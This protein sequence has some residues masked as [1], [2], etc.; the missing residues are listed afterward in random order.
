[1]S[2]YPKD[3]ADPVT[4]ATILF[5]KWSADQ[6][7]ENRLRDFPHELRDVIADAIREERVE[8]ERWR[9][10]HHEASIRLQAHD[11]GEEAAKLYERAG[12]AEELVAKLGKELDEV[13]LQLNR[14]LWANDMACENTPNPACECPGCE[15]ARDRA[16]RGET[17]P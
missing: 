8:A 10:A 15:T 12:R 13:E 17:Q 3:W 14:L 16:V 4:V 6:P 1:M 5:A 9:N 7:V 2:E 11:C